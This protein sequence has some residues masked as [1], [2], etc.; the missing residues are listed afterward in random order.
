MSTDWEQVPVF[1]PVCYRQ[2]RK[3][4][5]PLVVAASLMARTLTVVVRRS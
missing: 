5:D 1:I 4:V 3:S 2:C